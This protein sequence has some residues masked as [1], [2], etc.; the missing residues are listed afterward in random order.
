MHQSIIN[1]MSQYIINRLLELLYYPITYK[2]N[3]YDCQD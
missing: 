3:N 1:S 2:L